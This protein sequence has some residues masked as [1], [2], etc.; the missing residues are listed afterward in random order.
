MAR[1]CTRIVALRHRKAVALRSACYGAA[2]DANERLRL[3][4]GW[5]NTEWQRLKS[6]VPHYR[7]L[8]Q[9]AG[10]P[11]RF[12]S[13]EEFVERLPATNRGMVRAGLRE[14]ASEARPADF[15]RTTGGSTAQP[16]Q[17]PAWR[18]EYRV[19]VPDMWMARG[20]YGISP[21]SGLFF[22]WGHSHLLGSGLKGWANARIRQV[23]DALLDYTRWSAYDLSPEA[24]RRAAQKLLQKRPACVVGYSVALDLFAR[25][26]LDRAQALRSAGVRV[27]LGAA[28]AFPADDSRSLLE[29]LFDCPVGMECG[30]V[31]T[32][33]IAHTHPK[34][35]YQAF[36]RTY[37][38]E[39][40]RT[41]SDAKGWTVRVTSLYPRCFPLVRYEL[42]DEIELPDGSP[43]L[44]LGVER[45]RRV[46]GRCND[47]VLVPDGSA[48]HSEVFTHAVR[49]CPVVRGYQVVQ[50]GPS[51]II[52]YLADRPL[53]LDEADRISARLA[54]AH[55]T[56]SS[57]GLRRVAR[58]EQ[59]VAGKTPMVVRAR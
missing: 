8:A 46:L 36:W 5:W 1:L 34:G 7:R 49:D 44:L 52:N 53:R 37:F 9:Q 3:Q 32:G 41:A 42:G 24:M 13:W 21:F 15:L 29:G 22:L 16:I 33:L 18:S 25:A 6:E 20:W 48:L 47:Y 39:A 59:T 10:L 40:E 38:V 50:N 45:F 58:L 17:M 12:A 43:D 51:I 54:R 31:E 26:N 23:K 19:T 28:E 2:T 11:S 30:S 57:A 27:V 35:G 56:L 14:M 4:L 55:A